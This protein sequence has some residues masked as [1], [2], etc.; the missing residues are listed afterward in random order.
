[1]GRPTRV[2]PN[3]LPK[4]NLLHTRKVKMYCGTEITGLHLVKETDQFHISLESWAFCCSSFKQLK[5][6]KELK[7]EIPI[8]T[9]ERVIAFL[10]KKAWKDYVQKTLTENSNGIIEMKETLAFL[11]RL[12]PEKRKVYFYELDSLIGAYCHGTFISYDKDGKLEEPNEHEL[13]ERKYYS[14]KY[15]MAAGRKD[16]TVKALYD[17]YHAVSDADEKEKHEAFSKYYDAEQDY[18]YKNFNLTD[19]F[20]EMGK[21]FVVCPYAFS[22]PTVKGSTYE[23]VGEIF[24]VVTPDAVFFQTKRH[25]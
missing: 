15:N 25:Y 19:T 24:F 20:I 11:D 5:F 21:S 14:S 8:A 6:G 16:P 12:F 23:H 7:V 22:R 9:D 13:K 4:Y 10:E 1:M 3:S 17:A 2:Y 18:V